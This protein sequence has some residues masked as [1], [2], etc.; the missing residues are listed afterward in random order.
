MP[1]TLHEAFVSQNEEL[2]QQVEPS[3]VVNITTVG[4]FHA[5][6]S[7]APEIQADPMQ[8]QTSASTTSSD[9]DSVI[10][11]G[12][13]ETMGH[14][15]KPTVMVKCSVLEGFCTGDTPRILDK[16]EADLV[17]SMRMMRNHEA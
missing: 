1:F 3:M 6:K 12:P 16:S 13:T 15:A 10:M 4:G 9:D 17:H 2:G 11:V 5:G 8:N 14:F 7:P